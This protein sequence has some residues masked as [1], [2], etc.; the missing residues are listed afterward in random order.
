[1]GRNELYE[2]GSRSAFLSGGCRGEFVFCLFQLLEA[3]HFPWLVSLSPHLQSWCQQAIPSHTVYL[4]L[5]FLPLSPSKVLVLTLVLRR[6][7]RIL[8]LL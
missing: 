6:K 8:L 3:S 5:S 4:W 1:M 7:S 2:D